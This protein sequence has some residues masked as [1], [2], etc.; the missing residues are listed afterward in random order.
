[1][2]KLF[3]FIAVAN[4]FF[5]GIIHAEAQCADSSLIL[6]SASTWDNIRNS[7]NSIKFKIGSLIKKATEGKGQA[8]FTIS[9][10]PNKFL[11]DYSDKE[12]CAKKEKETATEKLVFNSPELSSNDELNSWIGDFSQGKGKE[13]G[14]L[15]AKCDKSCSPSYEYKITFSSGTKYKVQALVGCGHARDKDDNQY[16]L[17]LVCGE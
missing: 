1:M 6:A 5:T 12:Y 11:S 15:Y 8:T 13:G 10:K 9:S 7:E 4:L 3:T 2:Y 17:K 16:G 14:D